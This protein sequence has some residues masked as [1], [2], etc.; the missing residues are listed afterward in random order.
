LNTKWLAFFAFVWVIGIFLGATYE[1]HD[2]STTW[3]GNTQNTTLEYLMDY[4]NVSYQ[5]P[6][7]GNVSMPMVN[8]D[9]FRTWFKVLTLRF[10]F[11][12]QYEML[13][14]ILFAPLAIAGAFALIYGFVGLLQGFIPFS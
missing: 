9:Y 13:Y 11:T 6:V 2:T 8:G 5:Q 1:K 4:Q 12:T 10:D 7:F 14:W 3:A